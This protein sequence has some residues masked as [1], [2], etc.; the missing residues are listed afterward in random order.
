METNVDNGI[1]IKSQEIKTL[2]EEVEMILEESNNEGIKA[3]IVGHGK[4]YSICGSSLSA[5]V[6]R[7]CSDIEERHFLFKNEKYDLGTYPKFDR[8]NKREIFKNKKKGRL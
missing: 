7:V 5:M 2:E 8:R 1:E 3:V 4:A 6:D